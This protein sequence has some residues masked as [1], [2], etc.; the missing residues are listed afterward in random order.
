MKPQNSAAGCIGMLAQ[1]I[2]ALIQII[3]SLFGL[4]MAVV[5]LVVGTV[6]ALGVVFWIILVIALAVLLL[7]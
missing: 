5:G 7:G 2:S 1:I 3:G 4:A 6:A